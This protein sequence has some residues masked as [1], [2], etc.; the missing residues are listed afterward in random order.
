MTV[1][2]DKYQDPENMD[3]IVEE[4][5]TI[6]T[7]DGVIDLIKRIYP[8]WILYFLR[9]YSTDYPH[10]QSNWEFSCKEQ[11]VLPANII[12]V[13]Y[14][15]YNDTYRLLNVFAEIFT[16]CGFIVRSKEDIIPCSKC[17]LALPSQ[18]RFN[19]MKESGNIKLNIEE[20]SLKCSK[21]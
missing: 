19:Q 13:D 1:A 2:V 10:L 5:K 7:L 12:I 4:L 9:R 20:W 15:Q 11:N 8:S 6:G 3:E 21:C 18:N 14:F 17:D 16:L